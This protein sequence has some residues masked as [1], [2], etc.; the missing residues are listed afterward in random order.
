MIDGG[1]E[2]LSVPYSYGFSII[3]LTLLVKVAT[4]PL[5]Q[6]Q[7]CPLCSHETTVRLLRYPE[8]YQHPPLP[9]VA[10]SHLL[11]RYS[12]ACGTSMQPE[13]GW[14]RLPSPLHPVVCYLYSNIGKLCC[15]DAHSKELAS[16]RALCSNLPRAMLNRQIANRVP[17]RTQATGLGHVMQVQSTLAVQALAPSVKDLQAKHA[18][19]PERLQLE[20]ARLYKEANV[21][22][23]SGCLPTLATIPVFIGLYRY[24][25]YASGGVHACVLSDRLTLSL[26]QLALCWAQLCERRLLSQSLRELCGVGH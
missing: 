4:F 15:P 23:L 5:T 14:P 12:N 11:L 6:K 18:G 1:L 8:A 2:K 16:F 13:T 26:L 3:I 10:S 19:D 20:T 7:V 21:N 17:N 9:Y 24:V 25:E 22:P